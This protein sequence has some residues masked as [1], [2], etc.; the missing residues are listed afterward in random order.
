MTETLLTD[1][2]VRPYLNAVR[3]WHGY[4]RFLGLPT[5]VDNPDTPLSELFVTPALSDQRVTPETPVNA[6]PASRSVLQMLSEHRCLV[7]LGD[8]GGGKST[9][10]NWIAWLMAG[11]AA[12]ILGGELEG[13]LPLP[14]VARELKLDG[15]RKFEDLVDAFL[16]RPVAEPLRE[17]RSV[18]LEY[19]E[20]G[21]P[22]PSAPGIFWI[23][24]L[25]QT[26]LKSAV[27]AEFKTLLQLV[28]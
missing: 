12:G 20:S 1:S 5:M 14:I 19:I 22:D 10:V 25:L 6:W 13:L 4:I 28:A 23:A 21:F 27:P 9:L 26:A 17:H 16:E 3:Q 24:P 8:P 18:V 11:G 7:L 15:V 2:R